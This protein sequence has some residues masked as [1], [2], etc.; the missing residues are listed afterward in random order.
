MINFFWLERKDEEEKKKERT[1]TKD[2]FLRTNIDRQTHS[3]ENRRGGSQV[4]CQGAQ[5]MPA[6]ALRLLTVPCLS[7]HLVAVSL[8]VHSVVLKINRKQT[9]LLKYSHFS[10]LDTQA[11]THFI[12]PVDTAS[13]DRRPGALTKARHN[14]IMTW[15][16]KPLPGG[17]TR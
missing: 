3:Q 11:G 1:R 8:S 12:F 7:E 16:L 5:R 2:D 6:C 4:P 9:S 17:N 13:K 10:L 14:R 15:K